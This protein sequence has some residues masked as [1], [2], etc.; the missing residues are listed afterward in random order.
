MME[1]ATD[2]R[3]VT[4]LEAVLASLRSIRPRHRQVVGLDGLFV[5]VFGLCLPLALDRLVSPRV[6]PV[7]LQDP[8]VQFLRRPEL[9]PPW[10]LL[11]FAYVLPV[12][13]LFWQVKQGRRIYGWNGTNATGLLLEIMIGVMEANG[14]TLLATVLL[15]LLVGKPRPYFAVVCEQYLDG[16]EEQI[17]A[18]DP[19]QVREARKAFPSGHAALAFSA[20]THWQYLWVLAGVPRDWLVTIKGAKTPRLAM[21]ALPWALALLVAVSRVIDNH[22]DVLDVTAGS[23]LGCACAYLATWNRYVDE[24]RRA[25]DDVETTH[26]T[27]ATQSNDEM[28]ATMLLTEISVP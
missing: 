1:R 23:L 8:S 13:A 22:H 5:L 11:L 3:W 18:G 16:S 24:D 17:C 4:A 19:W 27:G 14:T 12:V 7:S 15:K 25:F 20:V 6:V 10:L 26:L 2:R 9:V 21:M 28:E